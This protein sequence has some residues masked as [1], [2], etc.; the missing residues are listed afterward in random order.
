MWRGCK[1]CKSTTKY[2]N[3]KS[4]AVS[5]TV[6]HNTS[7]NGSWHWYLGEVE[8]NKEQTR[9]MLENGYWMVSLSW[10]YQKGKESK[11]LLTSVICEGK[12]SD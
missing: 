6:Y 9:E 7:D 3:T 4:I 5:P 11:T 2:W 1:L 10:N 8:G 12:A